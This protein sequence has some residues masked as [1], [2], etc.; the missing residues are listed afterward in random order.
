MILSYDAYGETVEEKQQNNDALTTLFDKVLQMGEE[1][2]ELK[3][4]R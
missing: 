2:K 3:A 1:I 4:S